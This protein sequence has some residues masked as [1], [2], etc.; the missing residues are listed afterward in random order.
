MRNGRRGAARSWSP[1]SARSIGARAALAAAIDDSDGTTSVIAKKAK[2]RNWVTALAT[3]RAGLAASQQSG[4]QI[5]PAGAGAQQHSFCAARVRH[6][7]IAG[8]AVADA[9]ANRT[10]SA[11]RRRMA[12]R[13]QRFPT[14]SNIIPL[15]HAR[16]ASYTCCVD[17]QLQPLTE[18]RAEFLAWL[19]KHGASADQ[20]EDLLQAAFARGLEPWVSPPQPDRLVPWFYRVLRNALVDQARR[21]AAA[22]RALDRYAHEVPE[23]EAPIEA[24]RV[25][26][27][28][29]RA[30]AALK[31]EYAQLVEWVDVAQDSV[32]DAASRAGIT[33]NNAYVRLHRA[34]RALRERLELLCGS[35]A[36]DGGRC[37]DCYCQPEGAL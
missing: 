1:T 24:R 12:Q 10:N 34:R 32:E 35:C 25:C 9:K 17:S 16:P 28:T 20:A 6:A 5:A 8:A 36:T 15:T 22:G 13:S 37:R 31:P 26:A 18:R 29:R 4:A 3:A 27:C 23:V 11:I 14:A 7:V 33:A 19:R 21:S 2:P 30:L